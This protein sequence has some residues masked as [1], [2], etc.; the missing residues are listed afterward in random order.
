[1]SHTPHTSRT[2]HT[3]RISHTPRR[4]EEDLV[5][6]MA[7]K[8][9]LFQYPPNSLLYAHG[10]VCEE[11]HVVLSGQVFLQPP[12]KSPPLRLQPGTVLGSEMLLRRARVPVDVR[13]DPHFE[14]HVACLSWSD[15]R[16]VLSDW[17]AR[18]VLDLVPGLQFSV[19]TRVKQAVERCGV[20]AQKEA[21][22]ALYTEGDPS[23]NV[24]LLVRG[25]T[26]LTQQLK[27]GV[28]QTEGQLVNQLRLTL[29]H[30]TSV[31]P[32]DV[33]RMSSSTMGRDS[34]A[35]STFESRIMQRRAAAKAAA[36]AGRGLADGLGAT[37]P[38]GASLS[39]G[40]ALS[41]TE[42]AQTLPVGLG[43]GPGP[44]DASSSSF[45]PSRPPSDFTQMPPEAQVEG[46]GAEGGQDPRLV[47]VAHGHADGEVMAGSEEGSR[48]GSGG[49]GH[50]HQYHRGM[51]EGHLGDGDDFHDGEGGSSGPTEDDD[52]VDPLSFGA[53][54]RGRAGGG[55]GEGEEEDAH[56]QSGGRSGGEGEEGEGV[57][58]P[59][60]R[61][62]GAPQGPPY[63]NSLPHHHHEHLHSGP[64]S[65]HSHA[66]AHSA[67]S[68]NALEAL[69]AP[70][71]AAPRRREGGMGGWGQAPLDER[72]PWHPVGDTIAPGDDP[73]GH[74]EGFEGFSSHPEFLDGSQGHHFEFGEMEGPGGTP[75]LHQQARGG[76]P[77]SGETGATSDRYVSGP[78]SPS[79]VTPRAHH[80]MGELHEEAEGS[81]A[82][83][84]LEFRHQQ[85]LQRMH[86]EGDQGP[87]GVWEGDED[88]GEEEG[89]D[90]DLQQQQLEGA[91]V[92]S[93]PVGLAA[94]EG[95]TASAPLSIS[96]R[97]QGYPPTNATA[98]G[99]QR[100][101]DS[102]GDPGAVE[103]PGPSGEGVS[104]AGSMGG[105]DSLI[106]AGG[107]SISSI[108]PKASKDKG[109][110]GAGSKKGRGLQ[111][112]FVGSL[113]SMSMTAK[114]G[115]VPQEVKPL[116]GV[117]IYNALAQVRDRRPQISCL[118]PH[119][120]PL[121]L[122]KQ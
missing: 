105:R 28:L 102:G 98:Q 48:A 80:H 6:A 3:S 73:M 47:S 71:N 17:A 53:A 76:W 24:V 7:D 96:S 13:T 68:S 110:V 116:K 119:L 52:H 106:G 118:S 34:Q 122:T 84:D 25:Q 33:A 115:S 42:S 1:M 49:G 41:D 121:S 56:P 69:F 79:L 104:L 15:Y 77:E 103:A 117:P 5:Q 32:S 54:G 51:M 86:G 65:E 40:G 36:Q 12:D 64:L 18:R 26:M 94:A 66:S 113:P 61:L 8:C 57:M 39:G 14:S 60:L 107:G 21:G 20:Y 82:G 62:G 70:E 43:P 11:M 50:L 9:Q 75:M 16:G 59:R 29:G 58:V 87:E 27:E 4:L 72:S 67:S 78:V 35:G 30:N 92:V 100:G 55:W 95:S 91:G 97:I 111:A 10:C 109:K 37:A 2:S 38:P 99:Q 88:V 101:R 63:P 93:V 120:T 90:V 85:R 45:G 44:G 46:E 74:G 23:D 22:E 19:E 81:T 31:V 108:S 83:S 89:V 112:K 114:P